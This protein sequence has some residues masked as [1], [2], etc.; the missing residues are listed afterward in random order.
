MSRYFTTPPPVYARNWANSQNLVES[1][2]I[3]R[4]IVSQKVHRKEKKEKTKDKKEKKEKKEKTKDKKEKK[5]EN[6][7]KSLKLYIPVKQVSDESEQL[8]KSCLTEEH[9]QLHQIGYL[10]DGSQNS[11]KRSRETSPAVVESQIKAT[12]VA[13]NPLRLRFVLRKPKEAEVVPQEDRVCST[14]GTE[15]PIEIPSSVSVPKTCDHDVNLLSTAVESDKITIS[16]ESKKRKKHKQSKESRYNSLFDGWVPPCLSLEEDNS[17]SDDWLFGT[18]RQ[19]SSKASIKSD[20]DMIMNL[21]TS[22]EDC[23]SFPRARFLPEVGIF[24]LPYTVPF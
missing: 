3:E 19:A 4:Q 14:S 1:T 13:G 12:P 2:K 24:S 9:E 18:S 6:E 11:K 5:V 22:G 23:S 20:E 15:R 16:S 21:Q 7:K 10:S 8:E 17:N